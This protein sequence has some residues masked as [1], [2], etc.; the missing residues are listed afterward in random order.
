[1]FVPFAILVVMLVANGSNFGYFPRVPL[2]VLVSIAVVAGL[3]AFFVHFWL[4][5]TFE[6]MCVYVLAFVAALGSLL[7]GTLKGRAKM[8]ARD[9][10]SKTH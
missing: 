9:A 7:R 10:R 2:D 8:V 3:G 1:M 5:V 4:H 6:Q